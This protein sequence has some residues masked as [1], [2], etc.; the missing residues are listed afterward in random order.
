MENPKGSRCWRLR[1]VLRFFGTVAEP[2]PSK[3]FAE[4][5]LCAYDLQ[6]PGEPGLFYRKRLVLAA[7]Y[8]EIKQVDRRCP[9]GKGPPA[10]DHSHIFVRGGVKDRDGKWTSRGKCSGAYPLPLGLDW[11]QSIA[12]AALRLA[13][14]GARRWADRESRR[15]ARVCKE[16]EDIK[17]CLEV[18]KI[19]FATVQL[20]GRRALSDSGEYVAM[21]KD[22]GEHVA[23][24]DTLDLDSKDLEDQEGASPDSRSADSHATVGRYVNDNVQCSWD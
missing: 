18:P 19:G 1:C 10:D 3:Y 5:E 22:S 15:I 6:D 17:M 14:S 11:G 24:L 7:T 21:L 9:N 23:M 16:A 8:P 13:H 2:K 20:C 4:P 12:E